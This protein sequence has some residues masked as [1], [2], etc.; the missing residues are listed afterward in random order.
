[1]KKVLLFL[2][3]SVLLNAQKTEVIDLSKSIKNSKNSV[4][5]FTVVDQRPDKEIGSILFHKDQV[6]I[7][8]EHDAAT[9]IKNWFYKYNPVEG[10]DEMIVLLEKLNISE[11]QQDKSSVGKLD[12]RAST[13]I[14]RNDG[15]HFVYRKDTVTTVSSRVTPYLAQN[16]AKKTTLILADLFK[17]SYDKKEWEISIT[18][19]DLSNYTSVWQR[20][21]MF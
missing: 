14:K 18:E 3:F 2:F 5:T 21:L 10:T 9:D 1:M 19:N 11:D 16:L 8:F 4:K 13:F 7:V 12:L 15:Y 6:N 17:K 20:S